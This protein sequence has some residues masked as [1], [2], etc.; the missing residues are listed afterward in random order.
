M[1]HLHKREYL[2]AGDAFRLT[3][4]TQCNFILLDDSNY[5]TYKSGTGFKCH[6]G[7]F[8]KFPAMLVAPSSGY[9]NAVVDLGGGSANIRYSL[10]VIKNK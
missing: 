9:W 2:N 7:K 8:V 4:D 6:G 3:S 5:S 10:D 1:Q